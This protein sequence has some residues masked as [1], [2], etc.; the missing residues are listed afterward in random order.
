MQM[1]RGHSDVGPAIAGRWL[2]GQRRRAGYC[3]PLVGGGQLEP[4]VRGSAVC[5]GGWPGQLACPGRAATG[6]SC[7]GV[8]SPDG[9]RMTGASSHVLLWLRHPDAFRVR[10]TL[11]LKHP[12]TQGAVAEATHHQSV[13]QATS[14]S[15]GASRA[16]RRVPLLACPAVRTL[17]DTHACLEGQACHPP[18]QRC[19][20]HCSPGRETTYHAV[21][22]PA[23][24]RLS[25]RGIA[26]H[27]EY[28]RQ[29]TAGPPG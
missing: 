2:G 14:C 13:K 28:V 15:D 21:T 11:R 7:Q 16:G 25:L 26:R 8:P 24:R 10:A 19:R 18:M 6:R 20:G 22:H 27:G 3:R 12:A 4:A 29:T 23:A 1:C 17:F 9:R 5:H